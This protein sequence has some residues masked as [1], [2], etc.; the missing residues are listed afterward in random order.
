MGTETI[1]RNAGSAA[2]SL[3]CPKCGFTQEER[4]DC[5]KCGVVFS[6]YYAIYASGKS[7]APNGSSAPLSPEPSEQDQRA[8]VADIQLQIREI[9]SKIS[10]AEFEKAER[11]RIQKELKDLD[12]RLQSSLDGMTAR[13]DQH[14]KRMDE[15]S[16]TKPQ[17]DSSANDLTPFEE[18]LK[19]VEEK[20]IGVDRLNHQ[21]G[22]LV[23]KYGI[24]V[25]QILELR[26]QWSV[27]QKDFQEA[28]AEMELLRKA[29]AD[30]PP[31]PPVEE[32]IRTALGKYLDEFR[33]LL[34][35]AAKTQ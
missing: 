34:N 10:E 8:L 1:I 5:R 2:G 28:K 23:E 11:N 18:R 27:L 33:Q 12:K 14:E 13:L 30:A 4:L 3:T 7:S 35:P 24:N 15:I 6:K 26:D 22:D 17:Q 20:A 16:A 21:F 31:K 32:E 9:S 25:Q 29:Q 19:R